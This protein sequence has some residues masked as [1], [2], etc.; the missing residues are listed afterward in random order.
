M[1]DE[2]NI[3]S[4]GKFKSNPTIDSI[5]NILLLKGFKPGQFKVIQ[6][7]KD[8][9]DFSVELVLDDDFFDKNPG[10]Y[11]RLMQLFPIKLHDENNGYSVVSIKEGIDLA[12][13]STRPDTEKSKPWNEKITARRRDRHNGKI[14]RQT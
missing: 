9:S 2:N 14:D 3:L 5:E 11:N 7:K 13:E 8:V 6:S 12:I 10:L 4:I 1:E